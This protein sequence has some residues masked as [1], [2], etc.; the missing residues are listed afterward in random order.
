ML[1]LR[2]KFDLD[3][4]LATQFVHDGRGFVNGYSETCMHSLKGE[5]IHDVCFITVRRFMSQSFD[6]SGLQS[7]ASP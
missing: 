3:I 6:V 5:C 7:P 1:E 4:M 2:Q